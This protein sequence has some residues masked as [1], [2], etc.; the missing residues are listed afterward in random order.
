MNNWVTISLII[1]NVTAAFAS[2]GGLFVAVMVF[3]KSTQ[4]EKVA[5][6]THELV[7]GSMLFQLKL[8]AKTARVLANLDN[9]QE[10]RDAADLA[11]KMLKEHENKR[12][13]IEGSMDKAKIEV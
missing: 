3:K 2:L 12:S 8:H 7:N 13:I 6:T 1:A 9:S 5:Q 11:D 10:N 4:I